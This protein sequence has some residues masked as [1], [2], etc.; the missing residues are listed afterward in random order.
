MEPF[1][2]IKSLP[3]KSV[4]EKLIDALNVWM[5]ASTDS[6]EVIKAIVGDTHALS[7][8]LD[9]FEDSSPLR[10]GRP[11][12]H[13]VFGEAQTVNSANFQIV[14]VIDRASELDDAEFLR[15]VIAEMKNLLVGQS[16]DLY[17][18]YNVSVPSIQE[19]LQMVDGKTGGLFRMISKLLTARSELGPK[20]ATLDRLMVL[21]GRF[22][23]IRD[24]YSNLVSDRYTEAKG[25]CEDLDEG[26]CSLMLIHALGHAGQESQALLR[27]MYQQRRA[28]G[29]A[30]PGH[31]ELILAILKEA[32]S[33]E[34]TAAVLGVLGAEM[35]QEI[36]AVET[37]MGKANPALRGLLEALQV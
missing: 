3:S 13:G 9:D 6:V 21:L 8:M 16:L 1:Q 32:G 14:D 5:N 4:R 34:H 10:R 29:C 11:A 33:L 7:L 30:G 15:V 20:P 17:W 24:D 23:Q 26:K 35:Q 36:G 25:F 31:K 37:R 28:A 22:F 12:A 2:Y 19:Y 18:T 27:G